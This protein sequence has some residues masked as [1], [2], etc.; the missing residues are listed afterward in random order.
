M[1]DPSEFQQYLADSQLEIV[2]CFRPDLS[3]GVPKEIQQIALI[4]IKEP[5]FWPYI[6]GQPEWG[7]RDALDKWSIRVIGHLAKEVGG[8][9][10]FPFVASPW[11]PFYQWALRTGYAWKSPV[12]LLVHKTQG[13]WLSFRGAIGFVDEYFIE[14]DT[15]LV[16]GNRQS[17]CET[18]EKKPC[19]GACPVGALSQ[20]TYDVAKCKNHIASL[21]SQRDEGESNDIGLSCFEAGCRVRR[22]CPVSKQYQ[23]K[24][25][26][27]SYHIKC[28]MRKT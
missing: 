3:D 25:A 23:R 6:Q 8:I 26:H 5:G 22:A 4:G 11:L 13:L 18:C 20:I 24:P 1:Q 28:F 10:Y 9:A 2:G 14:Y 12:Q 16:A 7:D 19:I 15:E 21:I 17:P 27:S